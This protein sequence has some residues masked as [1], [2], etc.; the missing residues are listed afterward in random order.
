MLDILKA[1]SHVAAFRLSKLV[2]GLDYDRMIAELEARLGRHPRISVYADLTDFERLRVDAI[3]RD[4]RYAWSKR[5][6]LERFARL[7]VVSDAGWVRAL[8][9]A[10]RLVLAKVALR[11]FPTRERDAALRWACEPPSALPESDFAPIATPRP[12]TFAFAWGGKLTRADLERG[13]AQL[14]A[15]PV[16]RVLA[17]IERLD[18][19]EL[20]ALWIPWAGL[21]RIERFAVVGGPA[22]LPRAVKL[23]GAAS[24]LELRHFTAARE[25]DAWAWLDAQP[26][27]AAGDAA[28]RE[29][30]PL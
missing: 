9:A 11:V 10:G 5:N 3:A 29:A 24:G 20:A 26:V 1:P 15:L 7:A 16:T 2:S 19:L 30:F 28:S 25:S 17:R 14:R 13:S 12:D 8:S 4:V 27:Q 22:W 21:K 23:T 6:E 18:G